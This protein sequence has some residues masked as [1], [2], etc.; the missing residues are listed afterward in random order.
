MCLRHKPRLIP[1][2]PVK[3]T[4]SFSSVAFANHVI[5]SVWHCHIASGFLVREK[6]L[7]VA[8]FCSILSVIAAPIST[9]VL[10]P[11]A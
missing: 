9:H 10:L 3:R 2:R 5:E 7:E 11:D 1:S 4:I 6:L 8:A